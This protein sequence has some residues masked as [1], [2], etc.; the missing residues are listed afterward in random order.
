MISK[1]TIV[2]IAIEAGFHEYF[3]YS[4]IDYF[5]FFGNM[6]AEI[7][8]EECAEICINEDHFKTQICALKILTRGLE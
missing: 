5:V 2:E 7:E 6:I 8:R 1:K 3:I 4:N